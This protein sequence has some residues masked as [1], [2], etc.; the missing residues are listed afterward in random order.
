MLKNITICNIILYRG[1]KMSK[2]LKNNQK[3]NMNISV[4][5]FA[6]SLVVVG[7]VL[8]IF[9]SVQFENELWKNMGSRLVECIGTTCFSAGLISL[10][11]EISTIKEVVNG[12]LKDIL[13]CNVP[14]EAYSDDKLRELEVR[15]AATRLGV[16]ENFIKNSV[17]KMQEKLL[18]ISNGLYYEFYMVKYYITPDEENR[19]FHKKVCMKYKIVNRFGN[20]NVIKHNF[21]LY[22]TKD[23]MT[24]EERKKKFKVN[25]FIIN[26]DDM[27]SE[28]E[29]CI[30]VIPIEK[31]ENSVYQYNVKF[32]RKLQKCEEH[33]VTL[34]FE[35]DVPIDDLTQVF[36]LVLPCKSLEH[37]MIMQN[38]KG[39]N[40]NN[41][42]WKLR[43]SA[44][45]SFYCNQNDESGFNVEIEPGYVKVNFRDWAIPGAGYVVFF[46]EK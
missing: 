13:N 45:T 39:K 27:A 32:M 33:T 29:D 10:F 9:S 19:V 6:I 37:T 21:S 30:E 41:K 1:E 46:N 25:K 24:D 36:K 23:K 22:D 7:I 26:K 44:F 20:D 35:Y 2:F 42:E 3:I 34:E 28:I 15:I 43:A 17:Y 5:V 8:F 40:Q 12:A 16:E 11:L 14:L 31:K 4:P 38:V 18:L